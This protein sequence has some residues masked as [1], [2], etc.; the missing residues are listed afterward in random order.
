MRDFVEYLRYKA[1]RYKGEGSVPMYVTK[2][3]IDNNAVDKVL[4]KVSFKCTVLVFVV[5]PC[6]N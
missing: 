1:L 6:C 3:D 2:P 5:S 4:C